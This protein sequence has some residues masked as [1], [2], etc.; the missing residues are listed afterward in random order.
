MSSSGK[1]DAEKARYWLRRIS[2]VAWSGVSIRAFCRRRRL[3]ESQFC[4]WQPRLRP[5]RAD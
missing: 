1:S 3:R 5:G 4:S 2:E